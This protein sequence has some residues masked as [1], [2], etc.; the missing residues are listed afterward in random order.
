MFQKEEAL[1]SGYQPQ[2][3]TPR[4]LPVYFK[5]V[6]C[7]ALCISGYLAI[8][9]IE[10]T[11]YPYWRTPAGAPF[12]GFIFAGFGCFRAPSYLKFK[13]NYAQKQLRVLRALLGLSIVALGS[14][15]YYWITHYDTKYVKEQAGRAT[16]QELPPR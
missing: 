13:K 3:N 14:A 1:G 9:W 4:F 15:H 10:N 12:L 8:R 5:A 16:P 11:F 6:A 2:K 7:A